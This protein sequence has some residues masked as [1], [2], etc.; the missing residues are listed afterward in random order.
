M[1]AQP[2]I[3]KDVHNSKSFVSY[4]ISTL[5][6]EIQNISK[7]ALVHPTVFHAC[8]L[9]AM[10]LYHTPLDEKFHGILSMRS[11]TD[12]PCFWISGSPIQLSYFV[13]HPFHFTK[14]SKYVFLRVFLP[15]RR[16][17]IFSICGFSATGI[18][19][20]H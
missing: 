4:Y 11:C 3:I 8:A 15:T 14:Y 19:F 12:I 18:C 2:P 13:G 16:S 7:C 9:L 6:F 1:M 20:S 5:I 17:M 10:L